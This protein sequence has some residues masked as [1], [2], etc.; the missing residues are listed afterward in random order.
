MKA[1][2]GL[3]GSRPSTTPEPQP[4]TSAIFPSLRKLDLPTDQSHESPLLTLTLSA[5]SFLDAVVKDEFS[6]SPLYIIETHRDRT[7]IYRCETENITSVANVQWPSRSKMISANA[8]ALSGI[9]I[10]IHGGKWRPA[11]EFLKFGSLFASRKFHIPRHPHSLKWKRVG[12]SYTCTCSSNKGPLAILQAAYLSA[13]PRLRV[14]SSLLREDDTARN[15]SNY[16]GVPHVLLDYLIAT[17]LLLVTDIEE[18][19]HRPHQDVGAARSA[20]EAFLPPALRNKKNGRGSYVST[21]SR[22]PTNSNEN[23][24]SSNNNS[25]LT[26]DARSINSE[27]PSTPSST[28]S[29]YHPYSFFYLAAL[30]PDVPP[31]PE[32]PPEHQASVPPIP[33]RSSPLPPLPTLGRIPTVRRRLPQPPGQATPVTPATTEQLWSFPNVHLTPDLTLP[34]D[35][36]DSSMSTHPAPQTPPQ[37]QQHLRQASELSLSPMSIN[38]RQ[39]PPQR[40]PPQLPIPIPPKLRDVLARSIPSSAAP[41]DGMLSS[42]SEIPGQTGEP[43]SSIHE[44]GSARGVGNGQPQEFHRRFS[45]MDHRSTMRTSAYELPPPAYDAID[46]SLPRPPVLGGEGYQSFSVN[47]RLP[48][49]QI[50]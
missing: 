28:I 24:S 30:D 2:R 12:G 9:S 1:L 35:S 23:I 49:E 20:M 41:S 26:D 27:V 25:I 16:G 47:S 39:L 4:S 42:T 19:L 17:S 18:Y 6:E 40:R 38:R 33:P 44:D 11:E 8:V 45:D 3:V 22:S 5:P 7:G 50:S 21:E 34:A 37:H 46:F 10:Q 48:P 15:Q 32:V 36:P 43:D 29:Q 14:Y 13:P 31:V